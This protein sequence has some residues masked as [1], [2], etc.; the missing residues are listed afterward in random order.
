V[1]DKGGVSRR[2]LFAF[3]R[4]PKSEQ[5]PP[6]E[7][8]GPPPP[9]PPRPA[10]RPPGAVDEAIFADT[11]KRCGKCVEVCPR[12]AIAP[13]EDG[14]PGI[15]PRRAPCVVCDGLK[16]TTV[17]PSGAL[18]SL[19]PFDIRMGTAMI[20]ARRCVAWQGQACDR[21]VASCPVPGALVVDDAQR[22]LVDPGR[23]IGCGVCENVCPTS[24]AAIY[25]IAAR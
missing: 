6:D 8:P 25:V 9:P 5:E 1:S 2:E 10:L 7:P 17:C 11:C 4:R 21:C 18:I 15:T 23:C 22:P 14:T 13:L 3:W 19:A 16:C 20:D 12:Q 24:Q